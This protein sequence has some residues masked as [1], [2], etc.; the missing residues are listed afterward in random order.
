MDENELPM[1]GVLVKV[2]NSTVATITDLNGTYVIKV[3]EGSDSLTFSFTGFAVERRAVNNDV[4]D[5][6]LKSTDVQVTGVVVTGMGIKRNEKKVGVAITTVNSDEVTEAKTSSV[7]QALQGQIPG[8]NITTSS[9]AAGASTRVIFRGFSTINGSNQ[10]LFVI[11]GVPVTNSFSGSTSLN[12]GTDFGNGANDI[13]PDDIESI[14]FLKG[15]AATAIYGNRAANG[16]IIITTKKGSNTKKGMNVTINSTVKF[17]TPL[18]IPQFQNIYGQGIFGNWD[19]RENTSYGPKFDGQLH[20]WGHV[21]DGKRLI[22]P[23]V[24]LPNNV[25]DFFEIGHFVQ[26]SVSI[27]GG[28]LNTSYRMSFSNTND[29]G[30][31]PYD[32]DTYHRNTVSFHGSTKLTNKISSEASITYLNKKNKSVPTGQGGQSVYNNILQQPRDIPILELANY[33]DPF[34]DKDTYYSPYTTNPYWPLLENGNNNNEDRVY[35]MTQISYEITPNLKAMYRIGSDVSNRQLKEWRAKKINDPK[36]YNAGVDVEYGSVTDYSV[37]RSQLNSDFILTYQNTFGP[38]DLNIIAG[39][40]IFQQQYRSQYQ[41]ASN[42]DIEGF[43]D[44][45]NTKETPTVSTYRY[46]RR[47]MGVYGNAELSFKGW[48][49]LTLTARNDW[50]STLPMQNNSFFYPGAS[51]GFVFTDA[52]KFFEGA[53]KVFPYG[54]LRLSYGKTGNDANVYSVYPVFYQ[55]SRFPLPN[56]VNG[57]TVGN[58]AGNPDL[59]PEMT[60]ELEVG[61]DLRFFNGKYRIDFTYYDRTTKDLI[62]PVEMPPSTGYTYQMSNLGEIKNRGIEL[63]LET[64]I[65]SKKNFD[66]T[67]TFNFSINRSEVVN[68]GD[69][70]KYDYFGLLGGTEHWLR[71]YPRDSLG[72]P[73]SP[74]GV[75]EVSAPEI[76]TDPQGEK[77]V[78]VDAQGIPKLASSGYEKIGTNEPDFLAGFGSRITLYKFINFSFNID[79][80]QG[81]LMYSRTA[82]MVYFTGTTPITLYNDRQPFIVPNSVVQVGQD[83]NGDPIYVENTR[84]VLYEVLGGSANSY[85][86]LGGELLG[87]H[88]MVDKTFIKLRTVSL[89]INLP[90]KII[91]RTPF[92]AVSF[93]IVGNNLLVWTPADNNFIDPEMT[94]FGNDFEAEFG[95]FGATPTIRQIGFSL[96]VKF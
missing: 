26:N 45:S 37:W 51:L 17:S 50:S 33:K 19:Q 85:W 74:L 29:D 96:T 44:I 93:G 86:D 30:I 87:K 28:D 35:G 84:P 42:I 79:W 39:H 61:T 91:N 32:K 68:L 88:E 40:N 90:K 23:Y 49:N 16:V 59:Q 78:V 38:V 18:R 11:D 31:M 13:N 15:S 22:K 55:A 6:V 75:F 76:Y 3:P 2:A 8:V 80:H 24:G 4:I 36:G 95:E 7:L 92:G 69:L 20:Y 53:K 71:L 72:N 25:S 62:F 63:M 5:V 43:Y 47:L 58:S 77:H 73:G 52:F 21:V 89:S 67:L 10:P 60:S 66:W 41:S 64:N 48:L 83:A 65:V 54:K 94:T 34:F 9:G 70:E 57:F 46:L 14:S 27:E 12:G 81:G 82:G 1:P 56:Q